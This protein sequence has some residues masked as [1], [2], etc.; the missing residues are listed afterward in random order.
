MIKVGN[1]GTEDEPNVVST[2]ENVSAASATTRLPV[3]LGPTRLRAA[4]GNDTLRGEAATRRPAVT[5][6]LTAAQATTRFTAAR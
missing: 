2:I 6:C 1:I 3:T 4:H 5:T